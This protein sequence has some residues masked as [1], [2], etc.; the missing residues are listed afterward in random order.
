MWILLL[1]NR[2][3]SYACSQ[4]EQAFLKVRRWSSRLRFF[5]A[6]VET[7]RHGGVSIAP[8]KHRL[9]DPRPEFKKTLPT[10]M[11]HGISPR[12]RSDTQKGYPSNK[13]DI[14]IQGRQQQHQA[15]HHQ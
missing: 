8:E 15:L 13:I 1:Y 2:C 5:A 11:R 7:N 10:P 6:E 3:K 4:H 9:L 12:L 14:E